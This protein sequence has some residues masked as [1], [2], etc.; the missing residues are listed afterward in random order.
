MP[1]LII[2]CSYL[3]YRSFY[4][5]GNLS[6]DEKKVGVIF[7]F[8]KQI[9]KLSSQFE[10]NKFVFCWDSKKSYRQLIYPEYK[11]TRHKDLTPE[12]RNDLKIAHEQFSELREK[13]L[14]YMGFAN[15]F[16]RTGYEADDL[17]GHISMR[18][19]DDTLIVSSDNDLLQVL[20]ND[21]YC[22]VKIWNFK[23]IIDESRFSADWHNLKPFDWIKIKTI[24]GC[25]TDN[26]RGV[27]GVREPTAAKYVAGLLNGARLEAIEAW[28]KNEEQVKINRSLVALPYVG[29]KPIRI[30]GIQEDSISFDK[31]R[32]LFGQYGFRSLIATDEISRWKKSFFGGN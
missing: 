5:M 13:I 2:D 18:F 30:E 17:I 3:C 14:P 9:L 12:Q 26:I 29:L 8:L 19:P 16:H 20:K 11:E 10:T 23:T 28:L 15:I 25:V 24:S 21:R 4:T 27:A 1:R 22:P 31:F 32:S 6:Y 7:G